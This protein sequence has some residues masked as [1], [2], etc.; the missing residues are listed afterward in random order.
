MPYYYFRYPEQPSERY[1]RPPRDDAQEVRFNRA[2]TA[3][4][5]VTGLVIVLFCVAGV[6]FIARAWPSGF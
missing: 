6:V 3:A 2:V 5:V 4:A 1:R